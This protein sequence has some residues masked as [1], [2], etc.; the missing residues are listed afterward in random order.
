MQIADETKLGNPEM[1]IDDK[2]KDS[3]CVFFF[4][5]NNWCATQYLHLTGALIVH[6]SGVGSLGQQC[7]HLTI[8]AT[9]MSVLRY[10]EYVT[11]QLVHLIEYSLPRLHNRCLPKPLKP[12]KRSLLSGYVSLRLFQNLNK[13]MVLYVVETAS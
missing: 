9:L 13:L 3:I 12:G 6:Q 1:N 5:E 7:F 4:G 8:T 11:P 10:L 2:P